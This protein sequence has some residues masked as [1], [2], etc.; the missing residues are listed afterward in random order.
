MKSFEDYIIEYP[1]VI[2]VDLCDEIITR[3]EAD[4][5]VHPG[6]S[7][8]GLSDLK[9]SDDLSISGYPEWSDIDEKIYNALNPHFISY[10]ELIT[11]TAKFSRPTMFHDRGYQIQKT[12]PGGHYHWHDDSCNEGSSLSSFF[13]PDTGRELSFVNNRIFTYILYLNDRTDQ[14]DNGK[15]QFYNDGISKSVVA[16][17]GKLL[18]F[19]ANPFWVHRGEELT[20]GVKY[21]LTGWC[22]NYSSQKVCYP[23]EDEREELNL[24][25][26][27]IQNPKH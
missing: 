19:P 7:G 4:D 15:T 9:I 21:L 27:Y 20:S 12:T 17:P 14:L 24:W 18:L 10:V 23:N 11:R 6:M 2:S 16:E 25:V 8:M 13:D 1:D 22:C 3:F 5:R 26:D